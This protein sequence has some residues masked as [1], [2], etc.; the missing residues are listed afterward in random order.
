MTRNIVLIVDDVEINRDI[1]CEIFEG[2]YQCMEASNG[3]IALKLLEQNK[4]QVA[5]V[6]LDLFMPVL[7]GFGVLEEMKKRGYLEVI[8]V[9]FIT[10][11]QSVETEK[12]VFEMGASD[13]IHKPFDADIVSKRAENTISLYM[14][15][16]KLEEQV[17]EQT[18]L[19]KSQYE[20]LKKQ[21]EELN[22][23]NS[24]INEVMGTI[25]E[26]R[27][28]ESGEHIKRIKDFTRVLAEEVKK[29]YPEYKLTDK[30][31]DMIVDASS[32]HDIG[33]IAIPDSILL[34]PAKLTPD[35]FE[36]MKSH[37][38]KGCEII[39]E[40]SE[41]QSE[42]SRKISY[43]I[44]RHHHERYDGR[45]YPDG[46]EG[47]AI[48]IEA[49]LVSIADVYDALVSERVYKRAYTYS[50]AFQMII[51]GECG[52][53]SPKIMES[54]RHVRKQFEAIAERNNATHESRD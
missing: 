54:F 9:L 42:E 31:I 34:K 28:L 35:E 4:D 23:T 47:D 26:F 46:L 2:R 10:A 11:E 27:D 17:N 41:L 29:E 1:L 53:F 6:L 32:L 36:Y 12:R 37:T 40:L 49:Q 22:K 24:K 48:P 7:D 21:A 16:N 45:G 19:L 3:E 13:I 52:V 33:K 44:C 8:P 25:V 51:R 14:H 15:K 39:E 38:T 5:I 30:K 18:K 20:I 50:E 43:A